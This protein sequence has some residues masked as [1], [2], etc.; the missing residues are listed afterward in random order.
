M[1]S[2]TPC[3]H[4]GSFLL[5][6]VMISVLSACNLDRRWTG[7]WL[8][9]NPSSQSV[10]PQA[11]TSVIDLSIVDAREVDI[12]EQ[13]LAARDEYQSSLQQLHAFY[14]QHRHER[15]A[16]WSQ[17]EIE[18]LKTVQQF[19]YVM[20]AEVSSADLAPTDEIPEADKLYD[21][22]VKLMRDGGH[23]IPGI[24]R[25]DSMVEAAKVFRDLITRYPSS[26][27]IDDAA[28][29]CGEIHKEYLPGQEEIAVKWYERAWAWNPK[30]EHPARFQAAVV[31]DY[32]LHDRDRALE[33]YQSVLKTEVDHPS[34]IRFA[35]RRIEELVG[36][37]KAAHL[38]YP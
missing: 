1:S 22:A 26:D 13:V 37:L 25:R 35:A 31:Y 4:A 33:L 3:R 7:G 9:K 5:V 14:R 21:K 15:K 34:H 10:D 38:G 16:R 17:Q 32:R 18:G 2:C 28:F 8:S 20:E 36:S 27:K 24:F 6:L 12:V 23:G 11:D 30:I 19:R 29:F